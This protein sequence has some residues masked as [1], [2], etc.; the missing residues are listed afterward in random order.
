MKFFYPYEAAAFISWNKLRRHLNQTQIL[1]SQLI[2][3][4]RNTT[5]VF[6]FGFAANLEVGKR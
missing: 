5:E 1:T 4:A 3:V 6:L 2:K